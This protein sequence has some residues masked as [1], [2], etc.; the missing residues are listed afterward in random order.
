MEYEALFEVGK[1][2]FFLIAMSQEEFERLRWD[3]SNQYRNAVIRFVRGKKSRNLDNFY[4]EVSAAFQF[5]LYFGES[6]GAFDDC[7]TDLEWLRADAYIMLVSDAPLLLAEA[8][9]K[10][11]EVLIKYLDFAN[12]DWREPMKY[13]PAERDRKPTP[14]HVVF[15]CSPEM[16]GQYANRLDLLE[17]EYKI[18]V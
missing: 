10:D 1:P 4:D 2:T 3:L 14:F 9:S 12:D 7:L 5:P 6:W 15:Q 8:S 11:F 16:I 18:L 17:R 13:W